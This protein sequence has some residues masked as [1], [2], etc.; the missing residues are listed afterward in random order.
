MRVQVRKC[1]FTGK[2][3]Q[4]KDIGKYILHLLDVRETKQE[5]RHLARVKNTFNKWLL[6]ERTRITTIDEIA[7]W[8]M[9]NQQYIMDAHNSGINGQRHFSTDKFYKGDKFVNVKF[10]ATYRPYVSNTH[11]CPDNGITNWGSEHDKPTG[12]K[13]WKGSI[14]GTLKRSPKHDSSYP[15]GNAINIIGIKTGGGGGGNGNWSYEASVFLDDWPGLKHE[16]E[17]MERDQIVNRLKGVR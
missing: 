4:E 13:G 12:Y 2:I 8:F 6:K 10:H 3:F 14:S 15:Y 9:D 7:P 1:P 11:V 16:I 17:L 5:A